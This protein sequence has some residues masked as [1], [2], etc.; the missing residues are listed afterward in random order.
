VNA[1]NPNIKQLPCRLFYFYFLNGEFDGQA[2]E[3]SRMC[4]LT[5]GGAGV[6]RRCVCVAA[7][8]SWHRW[9]DVLVDFGMPLYLPWRIFEGEVLYR[10][11]M[12]LPGGPLSNYFCARNLIIS[13]RTRRWDAVEIKS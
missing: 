12:Y 2:G 8:L 4:P 3:N 13:K 9:P 11:V 1:E 10:D 5:M 6:G 7:A